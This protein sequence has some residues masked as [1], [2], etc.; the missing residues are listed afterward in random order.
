MKFIEKVKENREAFALRVFDMALQLGVGADDLMFCMNFET[1]GTMDHRITNSIGATGLIQ[2]MPAT[3]IGLGT[4]CDALRAMSNVEQL[5]Y[6]YKYLKP[7]RGQFKDY[8]DLYCAIFW[9][10]AVGK[11]DT[12]RITSD[13]VVRANPIFDINHDMDIE[14]S[15]IRTVLETLALRYR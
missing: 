3:A 1:A 5:E 9:P 6:V 7:W 8:V 15:E 4:T 10:A 14:K 13:M 2:F 12:Y 11:P